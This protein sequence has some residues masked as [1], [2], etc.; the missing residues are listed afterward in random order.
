MALA[1]RNTHGEF[2]QIIKNKNPKVVAFDFMFT[3][4][5]KYENDLAFGQ[6][7]DGMRAHRNRSGE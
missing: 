3:E 7:M 5:G 6:S 1:P 2:L 4:S